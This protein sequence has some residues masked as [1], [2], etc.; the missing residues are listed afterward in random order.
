MHALSIEKERVWWREAAI[1][2]AWSLALGL[3]GKLM[4]PLPFSP[5]P[6]ALRSQIVLLMAALLGPRRAAAAV[7]GFLA[8]GLV[9]LPVFTHGAAG[10]GALIGPNGGYLVGY[11]AAA[12]VTGWLAKRS[13]P[14]ALV[15][16]TAVIYLFGAGY[17]AT[18]VGIEKALW[19]GIVPFLILDAVK[20]AM[21]W[22]I[23]KSIRL[24]FQSQ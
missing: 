8:Q 16:G 1:V 24:K 13:L 7:I 12:V 6:L 9:G 22:A 17:L 3:L 5:V 23:V 4:I 21:N 2:V 15:A 19:L 11:V 10:W 20:I 14:A 18:F